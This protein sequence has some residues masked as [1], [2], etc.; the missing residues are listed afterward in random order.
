MLKT[1][2]YASLRASELCNLDDSDVDLKA[3]TIYVRGGKGRQRCFGLTL[4]MIARRRIRR[5]L[6]RPRHLCNIDGRKPLVLH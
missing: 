5:Y 6:E 1:M 3:L 2:F 4:Q